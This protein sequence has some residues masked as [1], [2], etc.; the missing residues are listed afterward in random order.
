[1]TSS[2][3]HQYL[4]GFS[5]TDITPPLDLDVR[6]GGYLRLHQTASKVLHPLKARTACFKHPMDAKESL[7]VMSCDL[8]GFQYRLGRIVRRIISRKT[9]VPSSRIILHFTH[10]HS[11]PDTIGIFPNRIRNLLTFDVQYPVVKHIMRG[12]IES[13]INAFKGAV[14]PVRIGYGITARVE[15]ALSVQRR[16]PYRRIHEPIR[17]IKL[18]DNE[19]KL[20]G[21]IVNYQGHPTQLPSRNSDIHPEYP[22]MVAKG[23]HDA[24]PG[25]QFACY[26]NGAAG[27]VSILGYKG[28]LGKNMGA[29]PREEAMLR[30]MKKVE[31]L[32]NQFV[33][34]VAGA[35]DAVKTSPLVSIK[36]RRRFIF[37]RIGRIRSIEPRI[38]YYKG[39][40][41]KV[42][43]IM[44]ELKNAIRIAIFHDLYKLVNGR[45]LPMLNTIKNSRQTLHQTELF[46]YK[47]NDITWF[48]SPGE[49]F[50]MY[51]EH[52]FS[53][54]P[55]GKGIFSQMSETCGYIYPW[56]FYVKGGYELFFSFDA[57]FGEYLYNRFLETLESVNSLK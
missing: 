57:L 37:P 28:Y 19:G 16:P 46:V 50:Y 20:L 42:K 41:G 25:L 47:I 3:E 4:V 34:Y 9:G 53:K 7:I 45:T 1:M 11:T 55:N 22:G 15:P 52:L 6:L 39:L 13:G 48:S 10:S 56:S 26:I 31:V 40:K 36:G 17:F 49:P 33:T 5:T 24:F 44:G 32:G 23:L 54:L 27:D 18:T 51:Q 2:P 29:G 38:K 43:L 30:A 35:I 12:M 21:I 8:V 14:T